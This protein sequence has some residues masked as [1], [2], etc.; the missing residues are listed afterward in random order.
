MS[1]TIN[2]GVNV[3]ISADEVVARVLDRLAATQRVYAEVTARD[4]TSTPAEWADWFTRQAEAVHPGKVPG[5]LYGIAWE[6][7]ARAAGKGA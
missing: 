3:E 6:A 4:M 7:A 2:P 1:E 5:W